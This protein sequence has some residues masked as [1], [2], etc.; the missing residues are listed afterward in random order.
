MTQRFSVRPQQDGERTPILKWRDVRPGTEL[1]AEYLGMR[2]GKFGPLADL[3]TSKGQATVPVPTALLGQLSRVR[4]GAQ[5]AIT[6]NGKVESQ[7]T[8]RTYHDFQVDVFDEADLLPEG[9]QANIVPAVGYE[10]PI[11]GSETGRFSPARVASRPI[12]QVPS[13]EPAPEPESE[14]EQ[15]AAQA[16]APAPK[17]AT[18]SAARGR[19]LKSVFE[20]LD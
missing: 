8:G 17:T 13:P 1:K 11:R 4:A 9:A 16:A 12:R 18:K 10:R 14:V 3:K 15:E 20:G 19:A 2:Q 5:V 7:K 6:Y